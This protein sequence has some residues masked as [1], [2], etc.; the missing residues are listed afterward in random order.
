M[1]TLLFDVMDTLVHDPFYAEVLDFFGM[2]L[3]DLFAIKSKEAWIE[4]ECGRMSEDELVHTYFT[5]GRPL[6]LPGLR[7]CMSRSYRWLD[8]ME[9]LVARLRDA[10]HD[11][12]ALSNYPI[13]SELL[14][15]AVGVSAYVPWTFVSWKTGVRK[16]DPRAYLG[17]AQRLAVPP[18]TCVF[19]DDREKNCAAARATG[20]QAIRFQS[21]DALSPALDDI[22]RRLP[23]G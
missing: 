13:W 14:D 3:E 17:A 6:D 19:I 18:E 8:G 11:L 9:T 1:A 16:P 23:D 15:D 2:P 22:L 5:D 12:H 10:G 20:M 4:F 21:A 7:A